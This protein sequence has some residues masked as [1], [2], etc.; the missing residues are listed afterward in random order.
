MVKIYHISRVVDIFGRCVLVNLITPPKNRYVYIRYVYDEKSPNKHFEMREGKQNGSLKIPTR[1]NAMRTQTKNKWLKWKNPQLLA[2][3][4]RNN[5]KNL[6][7]FPLFLA[8]R[9]FIPLFICICFSFSYS[10]SLP[11]IHFYRR[12]KCNNASKPILSFP[13]VHIKFSQCQR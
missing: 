13:Y 7:C 1:A 9:P 3:Q 6:E 12:M 8:L 5:E 4:I 2:V 11:W 10:N